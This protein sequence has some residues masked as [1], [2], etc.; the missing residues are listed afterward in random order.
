MAEK[1]HSFA[2][3]LALKTTFT[4]LTA[5]VGFDTPAQAQPTQT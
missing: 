4:T 5:G 2:T 3:K 1:P